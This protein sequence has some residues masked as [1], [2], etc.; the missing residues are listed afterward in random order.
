[1]LGTEQARRLERHWFFFNVP[2]VVA[3]ALALKLVHF[4]SNLWECGASKFIRLATAQDFHTKIR[5][6]EAAEA[7][8]EAAQKF[9]GEFAV[10]NKIHQTNP[11]L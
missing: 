4:I 5:K 10:L 3:E 9:F 6:K 1:V 8:N 7:Y 11:A 2:R